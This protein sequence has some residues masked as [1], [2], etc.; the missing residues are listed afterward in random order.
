MRGAS[1]ILGAVVA[2]RFVHV[3][4]RR[5]IPVI[6][7]LGAGGMYICLLHI[8]FVRAARHHGL[9]EHVDQWHDQ[10]AVITGAVLLAAF[11]A[12]PPVRALTRPLVKPRIAR[13]TG[14]R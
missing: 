6:T 11:L 10:L 14:G 9:H 2:V 12:S 13:F 1:I 5:R 7:Y 3:V 8:S 4:P